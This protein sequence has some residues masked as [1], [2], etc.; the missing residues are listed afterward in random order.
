L[1]LAQE[2]ANSTAGLD[3][4]CTDDDYSTTAPASPAL[5]SRRQ[6][7]PRA[8]R[9][10][11]VA[12]PRAPAS[13]N[14]SL[15]S[16]FRSPVGSPRRPAPRTPCSRNCAHRC[17]AACTGPASIPAAG[18]TSSFAPSVASPPRPPARA[19]P[20]DRKT[21]TRAAAAAGLDPASAAF[22]LSELRASLPLDPG[23][24]AFTLSA[25]RGAAAEEQPAHDGL[26][27]SL[28]AESSTGSVITEG[29]EA[30]ELCDA[31]FS[32][33]EV[34]EEPAAEAAATA[35]DGAEAAPAGPLRRMPKLAKPFLSLARHLRRTTSQ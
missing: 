23:S 20:F 14:A 12:T 18:G 21:G 30:Q 32:L 19:A 24:A 2:A 4:I 16:G 13:P 31:A 25:L 9:R 8:A 34:P 22:N 29:D 5:S 3:P 28:H 17:D 27:L 10:P 35:H 1:A 15:S 26:A 6:G 11:R 7:T 33:E